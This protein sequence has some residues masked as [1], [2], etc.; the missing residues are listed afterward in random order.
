MM[1]KNKAYYLDLEYGIATRP[2]SEEE[3]SGILAYYVDMPFIA[4]DGDS[5]EEAIADARMAFG[6][7]IDVALENGDAIPEPAHLTR[8]R[9]ISITLPQY[10]LDQ[11][12]RYTKA[13]ST[14]RSAFLVESALQRIQ[15]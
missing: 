1:K 4:G 13:H 8:T 11:I 12:N 15:E 6:A 2:L 10:A 3:G 7:W 5:I 9:R 14:N